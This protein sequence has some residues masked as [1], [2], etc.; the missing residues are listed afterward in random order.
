MKL[1]MCS[2]YLSIMH[3]N[4]R[5]SFISIDYC[6]HFSILSSIIIQT[7]NYVVSIEYNNLCNKYLYEANERKISASHKD[8]E[9]KDSLL[10]ILLSLRS[11][12]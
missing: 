5:A 9:N 10:N 7:C 12:Q 3:F 2:V 6:G 8:N 1:I 4:F 11:F